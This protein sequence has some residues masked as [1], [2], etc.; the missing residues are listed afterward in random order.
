MR[1]AFL[2]LCL[3]LLGMGLG[4]S[5]A[6]PTRADGLNGSVTATSQ[7]GKPACWVL[8]GNKLYFVEKDS[9]AVLKVSASGVL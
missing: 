5:M 1:K 3:L 2:L 7:E 8:L 4:L 6:R 9:S